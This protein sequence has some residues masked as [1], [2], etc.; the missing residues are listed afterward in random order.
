MTSGKIS[1]VQY[2]RNS[3]FPFHRRD[4]PLFAFAIVLFRIN[5]LCSH[6]IRG[7]I[8]SMGSI[9]CHIQKE[10]GILSTVFIDALDGLSGDEVCSISLIMARF[11]AKYV[12]IGLPQK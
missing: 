8:R 6:I 11:Y 4:E 10:R 7:H 1:H 2:L 9:V 12:R 3:Y 5:I